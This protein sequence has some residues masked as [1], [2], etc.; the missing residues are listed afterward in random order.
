[1]VH[2]SRRKE[3]MRGVSFFSVPFWGL[4]GRRPVFL[5]RLPACLP[6]CLPAR[7]LLSCEEADTHHRVY[8]DTMPLLWVIYLQKFVITR[9]L[10]QT[11]YFSKFAAPSLLF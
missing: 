1:M 11:L 7:L 2:S 9:N 8:N 5:G 4:A 3:K 6:V 10:V